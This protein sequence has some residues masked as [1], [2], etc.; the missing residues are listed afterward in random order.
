MAMA[1]RIALS[2]TQWVELVVLAVI[3]VVAALALTLIFNVPGAA[4]S[5]NITTDPGANLYPW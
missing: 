1:H 3:I 2:R 4:N 5:Y